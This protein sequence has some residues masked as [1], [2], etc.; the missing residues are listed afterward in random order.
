M[1]KR[2]FGVAAGFALLTATAAFGSDGGS[3]YADNCSG[4]HGDRGEGEGGPAL[5]GNPT[6]LDATRLKAL[7]AKG[8]G[9]MPAFSQLGEGEVSALAAFFKAGFAGGAPADAA[10]AY[11]RGDAS[12]GLAYFTGRSPLSAGGPACRG[13]H[14]AG[15]HMGGALGRDLT[16][17]SQRSSN[18]AVLAKALVRPAFPVMRAA[19]VDHALSVDE[20]SDL[21]AYL[22]SVGGA[23]PESRARVW[24]GGA[25]GTVLLFLIAG[26]AGSRRG[27][28]PA[29]R[30]RRQGRR[31]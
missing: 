28:S 13:C 15:A 29:Q 26:V 9:D 19:Y 31:S 6:A 11:K 20:A 8:K 2:R 17:T 10:P 24:L 21:A 4:C 5:A 7:L 23:K 14:S 18:E 27:E 30:L 25:A 16:Q 12:R 3:L 1:G 22:L